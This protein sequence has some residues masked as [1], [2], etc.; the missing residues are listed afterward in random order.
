MP[1]IDWLENN[2]FSVEYPRL[3]AILSLCWNISL[4]QSSDVDPHLLRVESSLREHL[5][6]NE[7]NRV[8][9]ILVGN[10]LDDPVLKFLI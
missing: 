3:A 1:L 10:E 9:R 7:Q 8:R 5:T 2:V 6:Y 4:V